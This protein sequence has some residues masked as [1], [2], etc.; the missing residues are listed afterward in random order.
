MA[1][2]LIAF[3]TGHLNGKNEKHFSLDTCPVYCSLTA[4][5]IKMYTE[6][7]AT[8]KEGPGQIH[9]NKTAREN[10]SEICMVQACDL[11]Y[12]VLFL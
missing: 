10:V 3:F 12:T 8:L 9:M 11:A 1:A 7:L 5:E 4:A 2:S 6:T